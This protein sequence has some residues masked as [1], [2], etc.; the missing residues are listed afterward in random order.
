LSD[1][2]ASSTTT[3]SGIGVGPTLG[4]DLIIYVL[5][6]F[7]Y[8]RIFRK[9]GVDSWKAFVPIY[10][11]YLLLKIV[12]R[13]G[14]WLLLL[15][16]PIVSLVIF[17]VLAFDLAKAFGKSNLFAIV[18]LILFPLVGFAILAFGSDVYRGPVAGNGGLP[19]RS[20]SAL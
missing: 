7:M 11:V 8:G 18:A 15:F 19:T 1:Y 16:I 9:A 10:N 3:T 14:W 4:L 13:P 2:N 20:A 6:S 17:I 12:G 5:V